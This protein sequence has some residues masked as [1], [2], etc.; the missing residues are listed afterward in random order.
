MDPRVKPWD[1]GACGWPCCQT[2]RRCSRRHHL[3]PSIAST[4]SPPSSQGLTLGSMRQA[5]GEKRRRSMQ[6]IRSPRA[7]L[8]IPGSSPGMTECV[9]GFV[10]RR[11]DNAVCG[12]AL[13]VRFIASGAAFGPSTTSPPPNA[14]TPLHRHP[15]T[16][17][18]PSSQG[19]TLGSMRQA[20]GEQRRRSMQRNRS[21]RAWLWVPGSSPGMTEG[22]VALLPDAPAMQLAAPPLPRR[23]GRH[24]SS[25]IP[26][27]PISRQESASRPA[28]HTRH[29]Q[30]YGPQ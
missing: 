24:L 22:G 13:A 8:W 11:T 27:P 9:V 19:L 15:S 2:H 4:T 12:A 20:P 7:W 14:A 16:T 26:G 17:S 25:V 10:A 28:A 1:D 29:H 5:P 3:C 18:P 23:P 6:R 21:P 30:R